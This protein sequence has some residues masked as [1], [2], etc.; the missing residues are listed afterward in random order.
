MSRRTLGFI[1]V[2]FAALHVSTL[3]LFWSANDASA[4]DPFADDRV[5]TTV[6]AERQ[7]AARIPAE[8]VAHITRWDREEPQLG[9][10]SPLEP[11]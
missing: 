6:T 5:E 1:T 10:F 4:Q 7:D 3:V 11:H 8:M 9:G 2:A